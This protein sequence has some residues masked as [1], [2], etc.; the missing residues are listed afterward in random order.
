MKPALRKANCTTTKDGEFKVIKTGSTTRWQHCHRLQKTM[1]L[2][3]IS[4]ILQ[5]KHVK[6]VLNYILKGDSLFTLSLKQHCNFLSQIIVIKIILMVS[7]LTWTRKTNTLLKT[8]VHLVWRILYYT[9][10]SREKASHQSYQHN[11][12][13]QLAHIRHL[14]RLRGNSPM[15]TAA[16]VSIFSE[17]TIGLIISALSLVRFELVQFEADV[18]TVRKERRWHIQWWL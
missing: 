2:H 17:S 3:C 13:S 15:F 6:F 5:V 7:F 8:K 10:L 16:F 9:L 18:Y 11:F 14:L 1:N 4:C 12:T